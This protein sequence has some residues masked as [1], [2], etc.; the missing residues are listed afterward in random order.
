MRLYLWNNL[1]DRKVLK[2][3]CKPVE[4]FDDKLKE[5]VLEMRQ[6]CGEYRGYAIAANQLGLDTQI[7]VIKIPQKGSKKKAKKGLRYILINPVIVKSSEEVIPWKESCLSFPQR[8]RWID[9][10][11]KIEVEYKDEEGKTCILCADDLLSRIIQHEIEHLNGEVF[12]NRPE[13]KG[14]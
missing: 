12:I 8:S 11:K 5:T 3:K 4:K 2:T 13:T 10:P 1:D 14:V 9:R 7:I 6:R